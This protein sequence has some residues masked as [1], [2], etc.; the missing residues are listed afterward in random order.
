MS[1]LS[2]LNKGLIFHAPLSERHPA[3]DIVSNVQ[4][5]ATDTYNVLDR[6]GSGRRSLSFNG[7]SDYVTLP[8]IPAFGTGD[9]TVVTTFNTSTVT[10]T[11]TLHGGQANAFGMLVW[12]NGKIYLYKVDAALNT[13]VS[14]TTLSAN[15]NYVII[16]KRSGTTGTLY[17]N[18]VADATVFSD[19][20]D[21]TAANSRLSYYSSGS[22]LPFSGSISLVR[23]FNYA[24][25]PTQIA[26]YSKPEYPIEWV[27][28]GA[29][30]ANLS[31]STFADYNSNWTSFANASATG[32]DA[33]SNGSVNMYATTDADIAL[34][35]GKIYKASW[36]PTLTSGTAPTFN[37]RQGRISGSVY[38]SS[39][40]STGVLSFTSSVTASICAYFVAGSGQ[41]CIISLNGFKFQQLGCVLD[42]NAEGI[43][44]QNITTKNN[45]YWWDATNNVAA[46]VSGATVQVPPASNLGATFFNGTTSKVVFTGMN[47]LTGITT[48]SAQIHPIALG[49][50]IFDNTKVKLK[51]NSSGYLS[52][53]RDG[54]TYINSGAGSIVINTTYN[55]T[56]TSTATG[57]TN[58]YINNVLSGTANQAA[59]TPAS[60]TTWNIGTD[61]TNFYSGYMKDVMINEEV[62]DLDRIKLLNDIK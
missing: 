15:T 22:P 11:Q 39:S 43:G 62:L 51:V 34:V 2:E 33:T 44:R 5:Q 24:L 14:T 55:I 19:A 10:T 8:T 48:I 26:N 17:I 52:F 57:V 16:Y 29:T 30:G 56:V 58:F 35:A 1:Q 13:G 54:S 7:S 59:G 12:S 25:T 47:G 61:A 20:N 36:T 42:L 32:F 38:A 28:R 45:A 41:S 23:I 60:E 6:Q 49:G 21:Y 53:S 50:F 40:F 46:T 31:T 27:D 18:G 37:I 4:G 3:I 9:F